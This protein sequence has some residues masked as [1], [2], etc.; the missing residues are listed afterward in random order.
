MAPSSINNI[1]NMAKYIGHTNGEKRKENNYH[2][3]DLQANSNKLV[4]SA[5]MRVKNSHSLFTV[6]FLLARRS[7]CF[8]FWA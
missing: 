4:F 7:R 6:H 8:V 1:K 2:G 3:D 5:F